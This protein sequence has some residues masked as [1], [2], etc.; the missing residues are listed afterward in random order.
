MK[1]SIFQ[2][3]KKSGII[4]SSVFIALFVLVINSN[5]VFAQETPTD[6]VGPAP[7][8][9]ITKLFKPDKSGFGP[10]FVG[11]SYTF[12][13]KKNKLPYN[14]RQTVVVRYHPIR[15]SF[16]TGYQGTFIETLGKWNTNLYANYYQTDWTY[17]YG[18]G[19]NS[20]FKIPGKI[21]DKKYNRTSNTLITAGVGAERIFNR[22]HK[23]SISPFFQSVKIKSEKDSSHYLYKSVYPAETTVYNTSNF[24]GIGLDYVYQKIDD[25]IWPV[26]GVAWL[27]NI[28]YIN[29]FTNSNLSFARYSTEINFYQ[30]ITQKFSFTIRAGAS[31]LT[32]T[33]EFYQYNFVGGTQTVR[34]Y[35][36]GRFY[37][38]SSFYNQNELRW[39]TDIHTKK[40]FG[41]IGLLAVY[42]MGRVWLRGEQSN[43]IHTGV[44][45]GILLSA[46]HKISASVVYA[47]SPEGNNLHF[48][49]IRPLEFLRNDTRIQ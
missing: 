35:E 20:L 7:R 31:T 15:K 11:I 3:V 25:S 39:I 1:I 41:K 46:M 2:K 36:K 48:R 43:L 28:T 18:L 8:G 30:P 27:T 34:G 37:G 47:K 38:N 19:N 40:Y 5:E 49:V 4:L 26:K 23:V 44:G 10:A 12:L 42:D 22:Y 6:T 24:G 9:E 13:N 14:S 17:F 29:N 45:G 33:P 21:Y 32:G 16:I